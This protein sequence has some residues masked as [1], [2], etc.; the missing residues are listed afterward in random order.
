LLP[1]EAPLTA[2]E[3]LP[4]LLEAP[5][6]APELATEWAPPEVDDAWLPLEAP[7]V[8]LTPVLPAPA[9]EP[10]PVDFDDEEHPSAARQ[11]DETTTKLLRIQTP[12][13]GDGV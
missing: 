5:A 4:P 13:R 11:T 12:S 6:M 3:W 1:D 9:A 7:A 8:P 2:A 10:L